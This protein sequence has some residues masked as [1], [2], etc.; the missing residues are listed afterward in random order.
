MTRT[1]GDFPMASDELLRGRTIPP[2][3]TTD[4]GAQSQDTFTLLGKEPNTDPSRGEPFDLP[5]MLTAGKH[6]ELDGAP[7]DLI[8][9]DEQAGMTYGAEVRVDHNADR[10]RSQWSPTRNRDWGT[11]DTHEGGADV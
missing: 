2:G 4:P 7:D 5:A 8:D 11:S 1:S 10:A 9:M 6:G 3:G